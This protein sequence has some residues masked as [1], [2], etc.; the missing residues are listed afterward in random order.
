MSIKSLDA[1]SAYA[2]ALQSTDKVGQS[3]KIDPA[4]IGGGDNN[5]AFASLIEENIGDLT[6]ATK[7]SEL[8]SAK[9]I[10]GQADMVDVVTAVSNAELVV[11]TMTA[12]RDKVVASY[13]EIIKLPI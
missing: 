13:N 3:G 12:V 11:S 5:S 9:A 8:T 7:T 6:N 4:S 10:A 2:Q 1:A